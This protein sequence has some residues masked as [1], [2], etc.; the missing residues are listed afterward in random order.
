MEIDYTR[1]FKRNLRQ[2]SRRYRRIRSDVEPVID[3]LKAGNTLGDQIS[4]IGY[5]VFKVRV[6]NSDNNKGK[7]GGYRVI[8]YVKTATHIT[9]VTLYSKSDQGDV[10]EDVLRRILQDHEAWIR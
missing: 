6:K 8:Y 1:E 7:S 2:L 5:T 10:E 9:M 4:G 3:E